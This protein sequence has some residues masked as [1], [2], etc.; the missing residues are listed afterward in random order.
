MD[1]GLR[2]LT[3]PTPAG[4]PNASK[5]SPLCLAENTVAGSLA[6]FLAIWLVSADPAIAQTNVQTL[7]HARMKTSTAVGSFIAARPREPISR[8]STMRR[9]A[10]WTCRTTG[11]SKS[12]PMSRRNP[13]FRRGRSIKIRR[14][15]T[16][17]LTWTAAW[18]GT[19]RLS[20][21]RVSTPGERCTILFDGA[22]ENADVSSSTARNSAAIPTGSRASFMI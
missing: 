13:A 3:W 21:C 5:I 15:V 4:D 6:T 7:R 11:A 20:R 8:G 14:R 19:A 1:R 22:Y 16:T 12:L 18:A 9:G 17:E 10:R 2:P